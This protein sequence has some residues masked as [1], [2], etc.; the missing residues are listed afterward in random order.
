MRDLS[1]QDL[2]Y[3]DLIGVT[4]RMRKV[5]RLIEKVA[6]TESSVLIT[7]P[8]GTGK[9]LVARLIHYQSARAQ[10]RF[11][12]VNCG[13]IPE[14]L[15]E[16]ELFGHVKGAFTGAAA[17]KRG[18]VEEADRGT[19]FLDEVA[20]MPLGSQVKLLRALQDGE[21]RRVGAT[22]SIRVDVR[23][24]AATNRDLAK[25]LE[26]G[27]LREDLYYRLNVFQ[28]ELPALRDRRD[29]IPILAT[30]FARKYGA[31]LGKEIRG[32]AEPAL[33]ALLRYPFPGN[34]RELENAIERAA[35]LAEEPLIQVRDLPPQIGSEG[36]PRLT[37]GDEAGDA[38]PASLPLSEVERRHI[39]RAIAAAGGNLSAAARTLG[40]GRS[41][42]WRK[43]R[44][45]GI[46][47]ASRSAS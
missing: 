45:Y 19:L 40:V 42:L 18:L 13:A 20:E 31:R 39:V 47:S 17:E 29:D 21:V 2:R 34:V 8:S 26:D 27:A 32:L 12:P 4:P 38:Y 41:T 9:E 23:I 14:H 35:V 43:M 25:A 37:Q 5:L 7:G 10:R 33:A 28:I 24:I 15:F 36:P 16:S 44:Q 6:P 1:L 46:K 11:V 3:G 22:A 30:H